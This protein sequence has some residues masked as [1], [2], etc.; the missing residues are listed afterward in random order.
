MQAD[1][2]RDS[3]GHGG[4]AAPSARGSRFQ[5]SALMTFDAVLRNEFPTAS[6]TEIQQMLEAV[7][8]RQRATEEK[9]ALSE[10]SWSADQRKQLSTLFHAID[11][12]ESGSISRD[13]FLEVASI[14]KLDRAELGG[15]Y[16]ATVGGARRRSARTPGGSRE[17]TYEGFKQLVQSLDMPMLNAVREAIPY[18][19]VGGNN[20]LLVF[21]NGKEQLWRLVAGGRTLVR[22][23]TP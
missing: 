22:K 18:V 15:A 9:R 20:P 8:E 10:A 2:S 1:K 3:R 23:H 14:C 13:E 16:D 5:P 7:D 4:S 12:D 6:P 21:D 11:I 19:V 17:L